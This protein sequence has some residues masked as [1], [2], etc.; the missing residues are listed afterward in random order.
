MAQQPP[1]NYP[2]SGPPS[3]PPPPAQ[4]SAQPPGAYPPP[5]PGGYPPPAGYRPAGAS[6]GGVRAAAVIQ[7]VLGALGTIGGI[8]VMVAG[9]T[10]LGAFGGAA[11]AV[12]IVVGLLVI[13][14]GV[15]EILS[16]AKILGLSNGWRIA[17]IV[18]ASIGGVFSLIGLIGS[19]SSGSQEFDAN[20]LEFTSGGLNVG[21]LISNLI[22]VV[23]YLL[24][25]ILLA[26]NSRAFAR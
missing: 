23:A 15:F 20:T 26:R 21:G 6:P 19:F 5:Q 17:G 13:A 12:V 7:N 16:G 25:I 10:V 24:V 8:L 18:L 14:F 9:G 2:P 22:G 1:G 4:P 11:G 3:G